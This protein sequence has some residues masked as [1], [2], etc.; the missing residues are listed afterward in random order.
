MF[1]ADET[2]YPQSSVRYTLVGD[3]LLASRLQPRE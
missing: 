1:S 2:Q 3:G